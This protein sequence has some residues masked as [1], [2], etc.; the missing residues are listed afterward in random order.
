MATTTH[1]NG[2]Y[3]LLFYIN[4]ATKN[5]QTIPDHLI[6]TA[7]DGWKVVVTNIFGTMQNTQNTFTKQNTQNTF[8]NRYWAD[9][10]YFT[11]TYLSNDPEYGFS[12][13]GTNVA[14]AALASFKN[15]KGATGVSQNSKLMALVA[16]S[17]PNYPHHTRGHSGEREAGS[18]AS[19]V[20][21]INVAKQNG[22]D[23]INIGFGSLHTKAL[24]C[25]GEPRTSGCV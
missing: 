12:A 6:S 20:R 4:Q 21:L 5:G 13:H 14:G 9:Y 10:R 16:S 11:K 17:D 23:V 22:A 19:M 25:S 3:S 8:T 1:P 15:G 2:E 24:Q 7:D 18:T